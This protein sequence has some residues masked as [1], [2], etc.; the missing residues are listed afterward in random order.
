MKEYSHEMLPMLERKG[1]FPYD[2]LD[3]IERLSETSLPNREQFRSILNDEEISQEDYEFAQQVWQ[4]FGTQTLGDYS[5]L[6][7][8][9]DILLLADVFESFRNLCLKI[10]KLDPAHSYSCAGF[11]WLAM[12]KSTQ[13]EIELID[14]ID[15]MGFIEEG[16]RGGISQCSKRYM[17]ANNKYM[18]DLYNPNEKTNFLMYLDA[19]ALYAGAMSQA[20]PLNNFKWV[21]ENDK[22]ELFSDKNAILNLSDDDEVGFIFEV[23]VEYPKHL[24]QYHDD[25]PFLAESRTVPED[26]IRLLGNNPYIN[27]K[28]PK[29]LL[30]LLD[31]HKYVV[32]YRMLKLALQHGLVLKKVH[33]VLQFSQSCWLKKYIDINTELR[34]NATSEF[35]KKFYKFLT[36]AIFGKTIENL[37]SRRLIKLVS[38]YRGGKCSAQSLI[39]R[40]N[41]KGFKI[42]NENLVA[43]ELKLTEIL[44]NKPIAIGMSILDISKLTTY[45]FIYDFIKPKYNERCRIAYT[46]TDSFVL[47]IETEDFYADISKNIDMF[48]TSDYPIDNIYNIERKNKKV[49][50]KF[51]DELCSNLMYE[52]VGLRSK[53]YAVRAL[54]N[55][56][57]KDKIKK[58]KGVKKNV[59]KNKINFN[60]YLQC[61][62]NHSLYNIEQKTIRSIKHKL[63]SI[64]QRKLGLNPYDTKRFV[65]PPHFIDTLAWGNQKLEMYKTVN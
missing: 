3:C 49:P 26:E 51:K 61:V 18:G 28:H 52:F 48:D 42:F 31:K 7:M 24:H 29:L 15:I 17:K 55:G 34:K 45:K 35:E 32:H 2:Y 50:N 59:V 12:L 63:Y 16:V 8:K 10:Y 58:S 6:Y 39:A 13:V 14:S 30:T 5:Q 65:V 25:Y 37:R 22:P 33:R 21:D 41:F 43:I 60:D 4:K 47:D 53:C 27:N 44:M 46:D 20:L 19:N 36:N 23:D 40:A 11:S 56:T 62:Q 1:V 54:D 57:V 38:R 64:N 9:V